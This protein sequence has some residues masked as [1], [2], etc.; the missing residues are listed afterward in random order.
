MHATRLALLLWIGALLAPADPA[1]A[2]GDAKK[3]AA[4]FRACALC[5]SLRPDQNMT[6]P[7]LFGFWGRKAGSLK[8]FERYSPALEGSD[9]VWDAHNLERWLR[10]PA[11]LVPRNRMSF[12]GI[13]DA[14]RRADLIAFLKRAS[15]GLESAADKGRGFDDLKKLG[16]ER[17]VEAIR[18]CHDT[19]HVT[20]ADGQ[21]SDFW[22]ANLRFKIDSSGT[23]P[24]PGSPAIMPAGMMGD[25]A[26]VF[27]AS[28]DEISTFIK[29]QC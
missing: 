14:Q 24:R 5:H 8:S 15:A 3:G 29:H 13:A 11:G 1:A 25:R 26:S 17:Q 2:A 9:I 4:L 21:S 23:G 12:G 19:F 6:G 16:P 22:E 28:P 10:S 18:Y 20:T 7:S 27:F